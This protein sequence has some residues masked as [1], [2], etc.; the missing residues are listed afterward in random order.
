MDSRIEVETGTSGVSRNRFCQNASATREPLSIP[1][2]QCSICSGEFED[3]MMPCV[4]FPV[5]IL[6]PQVT[7]NVL[8]GPVP[9]LS[10]P[11]VSRGP[12]EGP[13]L[14]TCLRPS[15]GSVTGYTTQLSWGPECNV[16]LCTKFKDRRFPGPQRVSSKTGHGRLR[17]CGRC[18]FSVHTSIKYH[19]E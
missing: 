10:P 2:I 15:L 6:P 14:G 19:Y 11:V 1:C 8:V 5:Y 18:L 4:G 12:S 7:W 17:Y 16:E 3:E 9:S 13:L